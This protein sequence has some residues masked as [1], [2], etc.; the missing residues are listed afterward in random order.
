MALFGSKSKV[1][2]ARRLHRPYRYVVD[3]YGYF[4]FVHCPVC[5]STNQGW[6]DGGVPRYS[7]GAVEVNY[8]SETNPEMHLRCVVAC[9][10]AAGE[11]RLAVLKRTIDDV[12]HEAEFV[13]VAHPIVWARGK[14]ETHAPEMSDEEKRDRFEEARHLQ[15]EIRRFNDGEITLDQFKAN[16]EHLSKKWAEAHRG[17]P[18]SLREIIESRELRSL[19]FLPPLDE[20]I[21]TK[22]RASK[23][24]TPERQFKDD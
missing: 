9:K 19:Y 22:S 8:P 7:G 3:H 5:L 14:G 11:A 23:S 20:E 15:R 17:R 1:D 2:D 10:C 24:V 21:D 18:A 6:Y 13:S 16:V 4:K 12:P